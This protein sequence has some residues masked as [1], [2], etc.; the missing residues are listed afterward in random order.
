M[1]HA[2]CLGTTASAC[3]DLTSL[4]LTAS[5]TKQTVAATNFYYSDGKA[6]YWEIST[7]DRTYSDDSYIDI[8]IES[9]NQ[10]TVKVINGDSMLTATNY[11]EINQGQM[12]SY[13]ASDTVVLVA[14][15]W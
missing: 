13:K 12:M 1:Y 8:Y 5:F 4:S 6:C 2:Y 7:P 3:G 15:P 10:V 11:T 14:V 9:K